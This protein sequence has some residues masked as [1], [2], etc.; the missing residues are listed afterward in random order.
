MKVK[1]RT[2]LEKA[3]ITPECF[4]DC[5]EECCEKSEKMSL[6]IPLLSYP[7]LPFHVAASFSCPLLRFLFRV[8]TQMKMSL[9][10][11]VAVG[12]SRGTAS[13]GPAW[14]SSRFSPRSLQMLFKTLFPKNKYPR[15]VSWHCVKETVQRAC[16]LI[17]ASSPKWAPS[18]AAGVEEEERRR[19]LVLPL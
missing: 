11:S 5:S 19:S 18:T 9:V 8:R 2:V 4:L 13:D 10:P 6:N 15:R 14:R 7:P 1:I 17:S 3:P 16:W 12:H